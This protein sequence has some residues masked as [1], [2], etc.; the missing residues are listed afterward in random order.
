MTRV[1]VLI[2]PEQ[3]DPEG[4]RE[5]LDSDGC[6]SVVSF[7]GL[8]RGEDDGV[9]VE[10]LEFDAWAER[11]PM[12]LAELAEQALGQFGVS[13]VVLAHRTGS[14]GPGEPIVCIHVGSPHR[15]EGFEACSWLI[16]E[17]KRQAPL[18]K[19][20]IRADGEAWKAG[21]G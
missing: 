17:L 7:V 3:L 20:E 15:A 4:L 1:R 2:E 21:L 6:G 14:V 8:T 13:S 5:M 16:D 11:L 10:R 19:K 9:I 18:W 12:V